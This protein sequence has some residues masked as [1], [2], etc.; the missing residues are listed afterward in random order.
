MRKLAREVTTLQRLRHPNIIQVYEAVE[1]PSRLFIF[2]QY[3][4]LE[5]STRV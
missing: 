4:P 2:M 5:N 3:V 1:T